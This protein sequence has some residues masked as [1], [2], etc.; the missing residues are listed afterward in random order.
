MYIYIYLIYIYTYHIYKANSR[1]SSG[2]LMILL[3]SAETTRF[4]VRVS[5]GYRWSEWLDGPEKGAGRWLE[6]FWDVVSW[7]IKPINIH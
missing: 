3:K 4:S 6:T 2:L 1:K 5:D 7:F